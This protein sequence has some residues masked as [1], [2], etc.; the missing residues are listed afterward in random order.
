MNEIAY[1][2]TLTDQQRVLFLSQYN[3]VKKNATVGALLAFFLGGL[4][5]HHF[6]MG[7]IG[8]GFLYLVFCWTFFPAIIALIEAFLMSGRVRRYNDAQ[9]LTI[10]A[11]IKA[12]GPAQA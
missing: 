1:M 11:Q 12:L 8:L 5:A 6:Y 4:G 9:A 2:Q 7:K 10:A 3:G